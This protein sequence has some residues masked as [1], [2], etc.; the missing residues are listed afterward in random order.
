MTI[1]DCQDDHRIDITEHDDDRTGL[2]D[3][4]GPTSSALLFAISVFLAFRNITRDSLCV[5]LPFHQ[6]YLY[7]PTFLFLRPLNSYHLHL[8]PLLR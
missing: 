8:H 2:W 6:D 7:H 4:E 5:A 3:L 1:M